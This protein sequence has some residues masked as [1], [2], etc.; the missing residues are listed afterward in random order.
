MNSSDN[1][2][3]IIRYSRILKWVSFIIMILLPC[4]IVGEWSILEKLPFYELNKLAGGK[5]FTIGVNTCVAG[6]IVSLIPATI[7]F[8]L[9]YNV[10]KLFGLY[11]RGFIL[12]REN[13]K[14]FRLIGE[15]LIAD[16]VSSF[17]L[18]PVYTLI[19]SMNNGSGKRTISLGISSGEIAWLVSG[20]FIFVVAWVMDEARKINEEIELTI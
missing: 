9:F 17:L 1:K 4:I 15:L 3:R 8:L 18:N 14:R 6:A 5:E 11:E 13:V 19:M 10:Y 2:K 7:A 16:S 12:S 20:F